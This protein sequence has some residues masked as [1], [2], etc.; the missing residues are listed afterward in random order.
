MRRILKPRLLQLWLLLA[1]ATLPAGTGSAQD[2]P[3]QADP[4]VIQRI[5]DCLQP[6]LPENWQRAWIVVTEVS[7]TDS[8]RDYRSAFFYA[9]LEGDAAGQP[10][11]PCNTERASADLYGLNRDLIRQYREARLVFYRDGKFDLRYD[12][13][14]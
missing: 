2:K 7:R 10:L 13:P 14:K 6:G 11:T 1:A 8:D 4:E 3:A 9:N 5:F 12:S